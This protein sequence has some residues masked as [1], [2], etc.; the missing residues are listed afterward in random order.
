MDINPQGD[1]EEYYPIEVYIKPPI[2]T[3]LHTGDLISIEDDIFLV[4]TPACDIVFNYKINSQGKKEPF[5]K[6]DKMMLISVKEFEYESL[7]VNKLGKVDKGKIRDYITNSAYRYH[8][9]PPFNDNTGFLVDFQE[10]RSVE[11]ETKYERLATISSPFIKDI[12]S[13]FSNYYSRQG[14]PTF[15]QEV[16]VNK[17]FE[18]VEK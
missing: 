14:Q 9:L 12:I 10:L 8:Y 11:F 5:R 3:N 15:G 17:L 13:R 1:F 16:I 7:C 6:A 18:M 2:K 4:L